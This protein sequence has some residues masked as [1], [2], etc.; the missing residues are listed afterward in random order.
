MQS[1]KELTNLSDDLR[2]RHMLTNDSLHPIACQLSMLKLLIV[3]HYF[4][5]K[6]PIDYRNF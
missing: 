2:T 5:L 6:R 4:V 3:L 1:H